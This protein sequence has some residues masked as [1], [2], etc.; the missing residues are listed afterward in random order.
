[1][2]KSESTE[3][4]PEEKTLLSSMLHSELTALV[5][6]DSSPEEKRLKKFKGRARTRIMTAASTASDV[7][8]EI[9]FIKS[10]RTTLSICEANAADR[11]KIAVPTS[12]DMLL[13]SRTGPVSI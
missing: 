3:L 10:E 13:L 1:M 8:E 12:N 7:L 2:Y 9:L 5:R 11:R 6:L 4:S